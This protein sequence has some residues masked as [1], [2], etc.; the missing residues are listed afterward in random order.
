MLPDYIRNILVLNVF[1]HTF[2]KKKK[3]EDNEYR[4]REAYTHSMLPSIVV[5]FLFF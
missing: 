4:K 3:I 5:S 2:E 1:I